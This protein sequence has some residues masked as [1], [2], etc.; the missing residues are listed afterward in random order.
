MKVGQSCEE[1]HEIAVFASDV[2]AT[3]EVASV[4]HSL[5]KTM[6]LSSSQLYVESASMKRI[7][8]TPLN[9]VVVY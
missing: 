3:A 2:V 6:Q 4:S 7:D 1:C 5:L 9:K 8:I